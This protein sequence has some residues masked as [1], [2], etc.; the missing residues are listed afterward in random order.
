VRILGVDY[1]ERRIGLAVSDEL[2]IAAH[3]LPTANVRSMDEAVRQ[4]VEAVAQ[5][6]VGRV[7]VGLPLNMDGSSGP[8]AEVTVAFC[9]K[10][11]ETLAKR[12]LDV[13]VETFDERLTTMR[14]RQTLHEMGLE[15]RKQRSHVDRVSAVLL[16]QDYLQT[17][18]AR[19]G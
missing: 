11:R 14:A 8:R 9:E 16:L 19:R 15:E 17:T 12:G 5:H 4:V 1:G 3:G 10:C 6:I 18:S 13:P 2:G 7:I